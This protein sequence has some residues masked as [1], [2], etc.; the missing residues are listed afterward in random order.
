[1]DGGSREEGYENR[2]EATRRAGWFDAAVPFL[3]LLVVPS[4]TFF[5]LNKGDTLG[6]TAETGQEFE[7]WINKRHAKPP[8]DIKGRLCSH[9]TRS[10]FQDLIDGKGDIAAA[11]LFPNIFMPETS[12]EMR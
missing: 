6:V 4:K 10:H 3:S 8:F 11:N 1:L 5:F 2:R 9:K 7:R 12:S